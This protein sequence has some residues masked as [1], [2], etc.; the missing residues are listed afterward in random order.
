MLKP[1]DQVEVGKAFARHART[2]KFFP[3]AAE[4]I[5]YL[6]SANTD[7][8]YAAD[9]AWAIALKSFDERETVIITRE[10]LE[11]KSVVQELYDAGDVIGARM[12]F[13]AA[14]DRIIKNASTPVWQVSAGDDKQLRIDAVRNAVA[15]GLLP[16]KTLD[17]YLLDAPGQDAGPIAGLLTGKVTELK[18]NDE[19]LKKRWGGLRQA[20]DDGIAKAEA[21]KQLEREM[22][23]AERMA[24][25]SHRE[26]QLNEINLRINTLA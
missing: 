5:G 7:L 21:Q 2:S 20:L 12:G 17:K 25:E 13:R 22:R 8:H 26:E 14:Y 9:E 10:I 3:T 16:P 15:K 24:F 23:H 6:P 4:I 18:T 11:A 1:Y 19:N